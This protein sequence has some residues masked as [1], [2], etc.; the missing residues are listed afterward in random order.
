MNQQI[1][2]RLSSVMLEK[3]QVKARRQGYENLQEFIRE[4]LREKLFEIVEVS[5]K[6][7]DFLKRLHK[8]SE[9]KGLY[10]TEKELFEKLNKK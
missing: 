7:M 9:E 2:I 3:A 10:G 6:E 5:V 1:N 8:I 4:L